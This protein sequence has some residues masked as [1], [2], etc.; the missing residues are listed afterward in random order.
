MTHTTTAPTTAT[1]AATPAE[2]SVFAPA[3]A[4][5]DGTPSTDGMTITGRVDTSAQS[6]TF[7]TAPPVEF[8]LVAFDLYRDVHKAIRAELFD[9]TTNVGRLDPADRDGRAALAAHVHGIVEMLIAHAHH[10][11]VAI[12]PVLVEQ[13]PFLAERVE[14]EHVR[15]EERM[16]DLT[17]MAD[18]A[19]H[20][21]LVELRPRVHQL[22]M[23]L[24]SFTSAYLAHQDV[25]ERVI[26]PSLEVAIGVPEVIR[27]HEAIIGSIPPEEMAQS[28]ALMIP[29][30]NVDDRAELL[31]GMQAGAPPEVFAGVW[32]L[33]GS[34]LEP[35]DHAALARR[36]DLF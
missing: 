20:A 7:G 12:Q 33:V 5:R 30:M 6:P 2:S 3:E 35:A 19:V 26:M 11:D 21:P 15:L 10:E 34:V 28:L 4:D 31:G 36:L 24:A 32:G 18:D 25:E 22:Y 14:I 17:T 29:A 16:E 23:E 1:T 9:V 13:L 8:G 27:L